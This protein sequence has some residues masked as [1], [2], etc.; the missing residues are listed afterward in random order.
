MPALVLLAGLIT[1]FY[2]FFAHGYVLD[3]NHDRRD[4]SVPFALVCQRAA[5][6][7]TF[8]QWNPYIFAGTSALGSAAYVCFYPVNWIAFAFPELLLPWLLTALLVVHT[9]LAYVFAYRL[10]R[11]L[12]GDFFWATV[13]ATMYVFS[14]AA[15]MQMTAEI[16]FT[17]FV[18]LPVILSFVAAGPGGRPYANVLGQA[19]A[20]SL[21]ILGGNPQLAVYG[22]CLAVTF[23]LYRSLLGAERIDCVILGRNAAGLGLGLI[24]AAPRLLPFYYSLQETGAGRVPYEIFRAMSLTRPTDTLRFFMP[25]VFGASLHA[26][27]LGSMNHFETFSAY[28]GVAGGILGLY[29][30]LFV[31]RRSTAFW[32]IA[33]IGIVLVVLGTP[34]TRIHYLGT[35]GAQLL[36]NRLAWFLPI[37]AAVLVAVHGDALVKRRSVRFFSLGVVGVVYAWAAYL[38]FWSL[39]AAAVMANQASEVAAAWHFGIFGALHLAALTAAARWSGRHVGV[40]ALVLLP[41]VLDVLLVARVEADNSNPFLSPPPFFRPTREELAAAEQIS[42]TGARWQQRVFRASPDPRVSSYDKRTINNRF[43]YLGLYNSSGYD[44]A[45]PSRIARLY[46]HPFVLN[47]IEERIVTPGSP[48]AAELAANALVVTDGGVLTLPKALPRVRLFSR[49]EVLPGEQALSRVLDPTFD[50]SATVVLAQAPRRPVPPTADPGLARIIVDSGDRIE[51]QVEA[52]SASV[53]LLADT[54]HSGWRASLDGV[55][56]PILAANYAFR[57]V[58]VGPGSHRVVWE[59]RHPGLAAG[60]WLFLGGL[61]ACGILGAIAVTSRRALPSRAHG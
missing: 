51:V 2:A 10:C 22:I 48:R 18:Y 55:D 6:A 54:Y 30:V 16:N 13:G 52:S 3:A 34:L 41:L 56:V 11:G 31:W 4:I 32:N 37:C 40:R 57:A 47:R 14:S 27:F 19:L 43:I 26:N 7:L 50:A 9:A 45:A 25:E 28:V 38:M 21:M 44:N 61:A 24:L 53:L 33:F 1:L 39:P 23:A 36:Y 29:A 12:G 49:Y 42:R 17:A 20:Y 60:I 15:V 8:P 58:T 46:S 59:F 35:G 5:R